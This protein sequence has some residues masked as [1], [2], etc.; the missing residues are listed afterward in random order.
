VAHTVVRAVLGVLGLALIANAAWLAATANRNVGM[1][2]V[3]ASGLFFLIWAATFRRLPRVVHAVA[4]LLTA[5]V[6]GVAGFLGWSGTRNTVT[7]HEDA[8]VVLGAAVHGSTLSPTLERRLGAALAYHALNPRALVVVSGGQGSG[9][10]LPEGNAMRA[11]LVAHGVPEASVLVEDRATSTEENF[12][13]S[14]RLL[15]ATLP[16][17]YSVAFVTSEFHVVRAERI[18]AASGLRATH[19][20]CPTPW[21]FWPTNYLRESLALAASLL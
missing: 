9:E 15:D 6:V 14:R 2:L 4:W 20:S 7:Y 13:F 18:A 3:A 1:A 17:G 12:A 10:D 11:Y 5:A 19:L 8:V 21:Y 16:A